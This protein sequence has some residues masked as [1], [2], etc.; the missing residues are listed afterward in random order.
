ML[1]VDW[2][3]F[4]NAIRAQAVIDATQLSAVRDRLGLSQARM[5][6]AAQGKPVG[7]EIYLTLCHWMQIDPL[8]F[9]VETGG[10][11]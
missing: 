1:R 4:G 2:C 9:A 8:H 7:T 6:N 10:D 11:A 5:I 3:Q